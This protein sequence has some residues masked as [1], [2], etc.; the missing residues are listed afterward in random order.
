[1]FFALVLFNSPA[2]NKTCASKKEIIVHN[3]FEFFGQCKNLPCELRFVH[4]E[5]PCPSY[6]RIRICSLPLFINIK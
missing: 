5:K 3:S 1:M 2:E 6:Q 4:N